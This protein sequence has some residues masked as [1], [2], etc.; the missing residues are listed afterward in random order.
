VKALSKRSTERYT[1][2]KDMSDDLQ[3]FLAAAS[4][5]EK[6]AVTG[7]ERHEAEVGTPLPSPVPTPSNQPVVK[8]VP[9]GLRALHCG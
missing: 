6:S 8:I 2:A 3:H 4:D 7:R 1:T 5:E 9:K